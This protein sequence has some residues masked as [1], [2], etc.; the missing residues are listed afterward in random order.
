MR[1]IVTLA[2]VG[3]LGA[4]SSLWG[5]TPAAGGSDA[6]RRTE[7]YR[8]G[9]ME[10]V[11][12]NAVEHGAT[13]TRDRLRTVIPADV[14]LSEEAKARGFRLAGYGV[15]FDVLVPNLQGTLPWSYRTLD[16]TD[17]GRQCAL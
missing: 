8:I 2:L 17:L 6:D 9:T 1:G 3:L 12:E 14:L 7:R 4:V 11:L 5:Q 13:V 15:F 16:Q 10:R